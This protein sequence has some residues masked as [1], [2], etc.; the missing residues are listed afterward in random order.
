MKKVLLIAL[1]ALAG[2]TWLE[3]QWEGRGS[4]ELPV[5][6]QRLP[7]QTQIEATLRLIERG[8]PFPHSQDG[9]TFFNREGRLPKEPRGYYREYTVETPG[10]DHRGAR[11]I[12]TGGKPPEVF[13]YTDD[14]YDSFRVLEG[15]R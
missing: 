7:G 12:V 11:R 1:L 13:Y 8:G 3:G 6:E 15:R 4:A 2:L 14:H 5:V 9:T 10:L